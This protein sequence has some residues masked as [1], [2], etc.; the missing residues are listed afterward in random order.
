MRLHEAC[1]LKL[2]TSAENIKIPV[3]FHNLKGYDSHFI[4]QKIGEITKEEQPN[5]S[6]IPNNT[7]KYMA[8]YLG[9]H[10]VFL[11]SFQFMS[12]SLAKL[13]NILPEDKFIYTRKY[14][15]DEEKFQLMRKKVVYPYDYMNS[16]E[17]FADRQLPKKE[18][19]L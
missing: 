3:F 1:N 9:K 6:V 17:K 12:T 19:F 2:K 5:I 8:F 13:A 10:L 11:D 18:D 15:Y 4:I 7:E 16:F 14:F